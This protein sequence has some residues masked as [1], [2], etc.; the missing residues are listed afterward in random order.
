MDMC[1]VFKPTKNTNWVISN[2]GVELPHFADVDVYPAHQAPIIVKSQ[3][4]NRLAI[5][6]AK[7]GLIPSWSKDDKISRHTYN[8]RTETVAEKPSYR[9]AW[10]HKHYALVLADCFYEPN[11][12]TGKAVRWRIESAD[13]Q[14]IAI[15]GLWD[16]WTSPETGEVV[17]SFT[18]LT[19]NASHHPVMCQFHKPQD[20]KRT[21]VVLPADK[22]LSWLGATPDTANEF[23]RLELIP[24]LIASPV[25]M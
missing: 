25:S 6:M 14:P 22:Y 7:F 21:P 23:L 17:A 18:M 20:E 1:S 3:R 11:Y 8:A 12:A 24:E 4:D 15:A 2:F 16:R 5:G 13:K 10:R 9:N 19:I